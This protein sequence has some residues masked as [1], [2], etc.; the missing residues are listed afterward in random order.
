M[1][2]AAIPPTQEPDQ[3]AMPVVTMLASALLFFLFVLLVVIMFGITKQFYTGVDESAEKQKQMR[4]LR[5]ADRATLSSYG[6]NDRG[7][8][9]IPID[10]AMQRLIEESE[11]A[12]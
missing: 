12:K 3:K 7:G 4:E 6:K 10:R 5:E 1:S 2:E 9:R 8:Y 11:R